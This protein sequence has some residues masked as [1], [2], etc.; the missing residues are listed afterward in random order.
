MS[1]SGPKNHA[2]SLVCE[3]AQPQAPNK[4]YF[5][6]TSGISFGNFSAGKNDEIWGKK[7]L[8]KAMQCLF[9]NSPPYGAP[10]EDGLSDT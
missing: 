8:K 5:S 4:Y 2:T 1:V 6:E 10:L 9:L 3:D 7:L